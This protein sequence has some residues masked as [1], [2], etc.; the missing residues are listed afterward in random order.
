MQGYLVVFPA[1]REM[2]LCMVG[3]HY[4]LNGHKFEQI[5]G[6]SERQGNLACCSA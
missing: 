3:W 1:A 6:D 4:Q 2:K 5:P